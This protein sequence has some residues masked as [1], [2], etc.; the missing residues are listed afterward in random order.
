MS[1][2]KFGQIEIVFKDFFKKNQ[3][4]DIFTVNVNEVVVS[5]R[6]S[7]AND[8]DWWYI[9]LLSR[10]RNNHTVAHG[11]TKE[12]QCNKS[13]AFTMSFNVSEMRKQVMVI[14]CRLLSRWETIISLFIQAPK[15]MFSYGV[16]Q[17]NRNPA[18]TMSLNV[19]EM[20]EYIKTSGMRLNRSCFK[21]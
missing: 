16:F 6:M 18:S 8:K 7:W 17:Y 15:N 11:G 3:L 10:S 19:P 14:Y 21:S 12:C 2:F 13:S 9:M 5:D 4:T 1:S 20:L